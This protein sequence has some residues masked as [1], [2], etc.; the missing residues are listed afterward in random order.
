MF[1]SLRR[2]VRPL[3]AAALAAMVLSA[4]TEDLGSGAGCPA[5]CPDTDIEMRDT[6]I[7]LHLSTTC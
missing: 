1:D 3:G 4:C 6:V 2:I 7:V 5:L